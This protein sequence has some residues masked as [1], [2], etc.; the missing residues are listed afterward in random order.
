MADNNNSLSKNHFHAKYGNEEYSLKLCLYNSEGYVTYLQRNSMIYLEIEDS[1]FNAFHTGTIIIG[2][3]QNIMEKHETPYVFLGNGRD[4]L[5]IEIS[6]IHTGD[7]VNDPK[8]EGNKEFLTLKFNFTVIDCTEIVYNNTVCKKLMLVEYAQYMLAENICNIFGIQKAG[9][10]GASYMDTNTGN[11]KATGDVIKSILYAVYNNGSPSEDLFYIDSKKGKIFEAEGEALVTLNPYGAMSYLE[12]LNYV[13]SFHSYQDS[14]CILQFDRHQKKFLLISLKTLCEQNSDYT[15]ECLKFPAP[16]KS[17]IGETKKVVEKPAIN[18]K[19]YPIT[20][21][22]SKINQFYIQSPS[23][24]YNVDMAGNS[25]ILSTSK[26]SKSMIFNLT[27]LNS[28]EFMKK[29][30]DM[31][32]KPFKTIFSDSGYEV[33][34]N[35]YPNPNKKNNY[36]TYKGTLPPVLDEKKFLNQKLSTLLYL[37]NVYQFQLKGKTHRKSAAFIDVTKIAEQTEDKYK[38][39]TYDRNVLGRHLLTSVK[40]IFE[41]NTYK[42]ELET[43]KP[44]RLVDGDENGVTL[45]EFLTQNA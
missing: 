32:V 11:A 24:K 17:S 41:Y 5:D 13:L 33:F 18:W 4:V 36:N 6:P 1:I 20:F 35:F 7:S 12:V 31:F 30:Y 26:S 45:S 14:P 27:T 10:S 42:N 43:I 34:P 3:D 38:A 39:S 16:S 37:N 22:E 8:D 23:C 9:G 29:F 15:I 28:D 44:Y 19:T 25:G 2:N 40:H 21:E